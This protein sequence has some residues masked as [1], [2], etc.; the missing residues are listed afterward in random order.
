M[1]SQLTIDEH[2]P[3]TLSLR[4]MDASKVLALSLLVATVSAGCNPGPVTPLEIR[5][6]LVIVLSDAL[7]AASLPMYG[8]DRNT[9]P[10]LRR[11]AG[12]SILFDTHLANYPGTPISV[13][14]MMSGRLMPPLLM[15]AGFALAPVR[16][17]PDDLLVLPQALRNAGYRTGIV[18]AH[19]WFDE[20]ARILRCFDEVAIVEPHDAFPYARAEDLLSEATAFVE[21]A[22]KDGRPFFLYLHVMDTHRPL[23][24]HAG[25]FGFQGAT[26]RPEVMNLYDAETLYVDHWVGE[27]EQDL[28]R[29]AL[30]DE[31]VFV[32]TSDHGEEHHE[33][34]P[35]PWNGRHGFTLRRAQ[36]H[37]PLLIRLPE[38]R[39][40]GLRYQGVTRHIDVAPTLIRLLLADVDLSSYT[41]DGA[42]LSADLL[43]GR[44]GAFRNETSIAHSTRYWALYDHNIELHFDK[45]N[46]TTDL[47]RISPGRWNYPRPVRMG[48]AGP[49][50]AKAAELREAYEKRTKAFV[51]M[52]PNTDLPARVVVGIPDQPVGNA[53]KGLSREQLPD[54]DR[55]YKEAWM[56]LEAAPG[57]RPPPA[58]FRGA[59]V[60]G[61]YRV[62]V[63]LDPAARRKNFEQRFVLELLGSDSPRVAFDEPNVA[64]DTLL[65]AG[66]HTLGNQLHIRVSEPVGGVAITGFQMERIDMATP[67]SPLIPGQEERL[68]ALGYVK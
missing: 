43:G 18:S 56:L 22:T 50:Q 48:D 60:P 29:R 17:L 49:W 63:R 1:R 35:E 9:S 40:G 27:L 45:W 62:R 55:W 59:W 19:P 67:E 47:F 24:R 31:T 2:P 46:S 52:Q 68:R 25:H 14:Q 16:A 11:L 65:D 20:H 38:A 33:M 8:Y 28:R 51:G 13:S 57:E 58:E 15:S 42:D 32:F 4:T 36:V 34:G 30:L 10:N 39:H 61:R 12:E 3:L 5:A 21:K 66:E 64:G 53:G 26:D 44:D 41:V 54:D 23:R 37:V 6:N 7:R